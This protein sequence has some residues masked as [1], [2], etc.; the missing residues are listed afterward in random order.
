ME[1]VTSWMEQGIE[2]GIEQGR[3]E[4][5]ELQA[6]ELVLRLLPRR[7]GQEVTF[8]LEEQIRQ[9]TLPQLEDLA[10]ALLDFGSVEDLQVW[11]ERN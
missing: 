8:P 11:L 3:M 7:I 10:D 6:I 2:R 1:I 4:G 5:R 9:L